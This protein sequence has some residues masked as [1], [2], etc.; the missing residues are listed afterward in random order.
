M[1]RA[2]CCPLFCPSAE[3]FLFGNETIHV[4]NGLIREVSISQERTMN[5]N[6]V[7]LILTLLVV[8]LLSGCTTGQVPDKSYKP[9]IAD[10]AYQQGVGPLVCLDEAHNNFHTLQ[11]R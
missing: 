2:F 1:E 9:V 5:R 4:W 3:G 11:G 10:P 6:N 8:S 7:K